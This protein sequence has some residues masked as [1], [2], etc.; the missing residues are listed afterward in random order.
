MFG[1]LSHFILT[2]VSGGRC[3]HLHVRWKAAGL[4]GWVVLPRH[5]SCWVVELRS[6]SRCFWLQGDSGLRGHGV[7][8]TVV[9]VLAL[10][11]ISCVTLARLFNWLIWSSMSDNVQLPLLL[12]TFLGNPLS[13]LILGQLQ[14]SF[15]GPLFT[16]NMVI[17]A[18]LLC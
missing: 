4:G 8:Q 10:L 14:N 3:H 7:R 16:I 5:F 12:T 6:N 11:L 15:S 2:E 9:H 17:L 18:S 13:L 1:K